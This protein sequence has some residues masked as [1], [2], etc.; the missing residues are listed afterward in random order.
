MLSLKSK[1][2]RRLTNLFG[3]FYGRASVWGWC[4]PM[5]AS[6][7]NWLCRWCKDRRDR[8]IVDRFASCTRNRWWSGPFG[9]PCFAALYLEQNGR[10]LDRGSGDE[11]RRGDDPCTRIQGVSE[12]GRWWW[13]CDAKLAPPSENFSIVWRRGEWNKRASKLV[14]NNTGLRNCWS[15][16]KRFL[17]FWIRI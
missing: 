1:K 15:S 8:R 16:I 17:T 11:R 4:D 6:S 13:Y 9:V 2:L 10:R 3:W 7:N 5:D 14:N 12:R